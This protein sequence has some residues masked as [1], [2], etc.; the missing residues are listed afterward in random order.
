MNKLSLCDNGDTKKM[1]EKK[2]NKDISSMLASF[3][4]FTKNQ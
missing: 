2:K 3:R 1:E 4:L